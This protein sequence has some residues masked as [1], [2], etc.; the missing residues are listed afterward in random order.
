[1]NGLGHHARA[2]RDHRFTRRHASEYVDG[3]LP[4]AGR[5]RVERH[6]EICPGCRRLVETLKRTVTAVRA[7]GDKPRPG[8][9]DRII[10]RLREQ[11]INGAP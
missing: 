8:L 10:G 9:S 7:L 3:E 6:T 2:M 5:R 11:E 1:M 4:E